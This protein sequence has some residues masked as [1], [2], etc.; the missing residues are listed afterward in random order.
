MTPQGH[1]PASTPAHEIWD[2]VHSW[3]IPSSESAGLA[4]RVAV[5]GP[6]PTAPQNGS[7]LQIEP[8]RG[9]PVVFLHGLVGLNDHWETAVVGLRARLWCVGF[10]LPLLNLRGDDCSIEGV[11]ALTASFLRQHFHTPPI[12]VGNS[13]G[14]HVALRIALEH[15]DLC[16]AL[17]LAG[18]SG[19]L[20]Q[21]TVAEVQ[22]R[23]SHEWLQKK[24]GELFYNSA[25]MN[26]ADVDRAFEEL[27]NRDS[28]RA[29]IRLSRSARRDVLRDRINAI[30]Q[31]TLLM[32]G[33]Q[34]VVTPPA[35]AE[36]FHQKIKNSRLV[37]FDNCGHVPMVEASQGF[38]DEMLRFAHHLGAQAV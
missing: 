15:P 17:V 26:P 36:A 33:R 13:F 23:P 20:E 21:S 12:L 9:I 37:W 25:A 6:G 27:S 19:M 5:A 14:G 18:S 29:M 7:A 30:A 32:W 11:T 24:I 28:A 38:I 34:D 1:T 4:A 16:G 3:P 35:A 22:I 2:R 8:A 10:E 31:P